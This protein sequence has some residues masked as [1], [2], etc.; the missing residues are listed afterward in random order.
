MFEQN[1][2]LDIQRETSV[3]EFIPTYKCTV[4]HLLYTLGP[5]Q[6]IN[7]LASGLLTGSTGHRMAMANWQASHISG[8]AVQWSLLTYVRLASGDK[9]KAGGS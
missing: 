7:F 4:V 5:E 6:G 1:S 8:W 3:Y 9:G 2:W